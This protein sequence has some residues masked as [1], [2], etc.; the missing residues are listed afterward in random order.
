LGDILGC[1]SSQSLLPLFSEL[2]LGACPLIAGSCFAALESAGRLF[3]CGDFSGKW[4]G[5][6]LGKFSVAVTAGSSLAIDNISL[7]SKLAN[8]LQNNKIGLS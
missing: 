6:E 5:S 8:S 3:F 7:L 1:P 4:L 2:I